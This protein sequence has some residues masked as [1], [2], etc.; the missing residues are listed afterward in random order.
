MEMGSGKFRGRDV[1]GSGQELGET[2]TAMDMRG[3]QVVVK[4]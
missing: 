2:F 3:S 1:V 4:D